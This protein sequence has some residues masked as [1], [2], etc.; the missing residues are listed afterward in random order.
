MNIPDNGTIQS[1]KDN[2]NSIIMNNQELDTIIFD[3]HDHLNYGTI[4][5]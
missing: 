4:D 1:S 2:L 3:R 5:L